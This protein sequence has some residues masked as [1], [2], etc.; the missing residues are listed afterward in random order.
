MKDINKRFRRWWVL[1]VLGFQWAMVVTVYHWIG[2][3][4]N[5]IVGWIS[6]QYLTSYI[7]EIKENQKERDDD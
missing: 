7:E 5:I 4:L 3:P 2:L 6:L 1:T